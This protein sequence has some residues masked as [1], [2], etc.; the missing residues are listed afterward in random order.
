ME[1]VVDLFMFMGQSNMAGRGVTSEQWP[2][3]A[4]ELIKGAGYEFRAISDASMLYPMKEPFG[5]NENNPEG[6]TEQSKTG[7]LVTAFVNA[8]Y[9]ETGIP[10]VGVSA[11]K[12]GSK[13]AEWQPG[14]PY[15]VD[16]I[17]RMKAAVQFL[18]SHGYNIRHKFMVWCQGE[19][20]GDIGK[21]MDT[22]QLDFEHMLKNMLE[23][24]IE[25]CYMIQIGNYNGTGKQDYTQ[26]QKAQV[27]IAREN[28][29]VVLVSTEFAG[30]KE[31]GLMKDDFHYFQAAY[32]E[33]GTNAGRKT[34]FHVMQHN[35]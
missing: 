17:Q 26:I 34:A 11:A 6:I 5:V 8:Y 13:I 4:P 30:M 19:S 2:E 9:K 1:Q 25:A 3:R 33:V 10:I 31:R 20:D 27:K 15:L 29:K 14:M 16:T 7:S 24:G 35:E 18:I 32:N 23:C 12:G 22:Y 21:S 28:R